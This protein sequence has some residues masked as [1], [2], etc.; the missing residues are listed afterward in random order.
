MKL[1]RFIPVFLTLIYVAGC[2]SAPPPTGHPSSMTW[3][4]PGVSAGQTE[5]D[6][7]A[8]Q[9]YAMVNAGGYSVQGDTLGQTMVLGMVA[10]SAQQSRENQLIQSR[11]TSLGY[12]L[13]K[14]NSPLLNSV[15]IADTR[16]G[17]FENAN[18]KI[19]ARAEG[20]DADA[21]YQLGTLYY[22]GDFGF[23]KDFTEAIKWYQ[24]AADQ[25]YPNMQLPLA[26]AYAM[27]GALEQKERDLDRALADFNKAIEVK[28]DFTEMYMIR[29]FVKQYKGDSDGAMADYCKAIELNPKFAG[30]YCGKSLA[31][32][33]S[34]N[35]TD[36]LADIRKACELGLDA[37]IVDYCHLYIWLI[38]AR[39][40]E[41]DN[42]NKEL[43]TYW[44]GRK[45][46][47]PDDWP[48][49]VAGFLTGQLTE[50]RFF[51]AAENTD[52]QTD[53]KQHCE[54]YFYAGSKRLIEG[55][56]TTASEYF[57]KCLATGCN[58]IDEYHSAAAELTGLKTSE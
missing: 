54:A 10:Q 31:N 11:M 51:K 58:N 16:P 5:R 13:V 48:S 45:A 23:T 20:G 22:T 46:G 55:D 40:G 39:L 41:K 35:F 49:N 52:N 1:K 18:A 21:Q 24:K 34:R 28:P 37:D 27:R 17:P 36:A 30:A 2:A 57:K 3:Y 42:A 38:Q 6:L 26:S 29:G 9:Y 4:Q 8:C 32:Y 12:S 33:D 44:N 19:R 53:Q 47:T 15:P 43:Q 56:K 14:T 50:A 25:N 7:A